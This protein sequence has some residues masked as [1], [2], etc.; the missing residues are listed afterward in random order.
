MLSEALD[1]APPRS[2]LEAMNALSHWIEGVENLLDVE[3]FRVT[4]LKGLEE[5]Y[6]QFRVSVINCIMQGQHH[7]ECTG[8]PF[9]VVENWLETAPY[10][11][12]EL[13]G[14]KELHIVMVISRNMH[15][16]FPLQNLL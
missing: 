16:L 7:F 5:Q 6:T 8:S 1:R 3:P 11:V 4:E 15:R 10:R 12:T 9:T 2:Y 14:L 13:K